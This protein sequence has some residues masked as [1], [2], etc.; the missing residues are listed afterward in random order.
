MRRKNRQFKVKKFYSVFISLLTLIT[1]AFSPVYTVFA[2]DIEYGNLNISF[3]DEGTKVNGEINKKYIEGATF[4]TSLVAVQENGEFVWIDELKNNEKLE[5]KTSDMFDENK[6]EDVSNKL[7]EIVE[8]DIKIEKLHKKTDEN[9][10]CSFSNI[11]K[12]IYLVWQTDSEGMASKYTLAV[13]FLTEIP[14]RAEDSSDYNVEVFP[15]TT[16]ITEKLI[17]VAGNKYWFKDKESDRPETI[18]L[19]L[20]ANDVEIANTTTSA[21]KGWAFSFP[22]VNAL[23]NNGDEVVFTIKE[24]TIKDY[25]FT[26]EAPTYG[27]NTVIINVNNTYDFE[28]PGTGVETHAKLWFVLML[29]S[30]ALLLFMIDKENKQMKK[31]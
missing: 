15:K 9:G 5:Y 24:D 16:L 10:Q 22:D 30:F 11:K 29:G 7:V 12:G 3:V 27:E 31:R 21:E 13:P 1:G 26:Q 18:T 25:K 14:N 6:F 2:D 17:T 4:A 23:D 20:F 28:D 19:R 8:D